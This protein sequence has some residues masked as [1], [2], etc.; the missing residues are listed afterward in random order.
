MQNWIVNWM[1]LDWRF[2]SEKRTKKNDIWKR[3]LVFISKNLTI[4][5]EKIH[6]I[7]IQMTS[8]NTEFNGE[9]NDTR[10][11]IQIEVKM[12]E[13]NK[14]KRHWEGKVCGNYKKFHNFT[15]TNSL[16]SNSNDTKKC[17]IQPWIQRYSIEDA[18]RSENCRKKQRK[19]TLGTESLS[20]LQKIW[21]FSKRKFAEF[22][23]KWHGQMQNPKMN[24]AILDWRFKSKWN[25]E[26]K[27][28]NKDIWKRKFVLIT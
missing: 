28:K 20:W 13:K 22:E 4:S 15:R 8:G 27:A 24:L 23:F 2:E 21:Q 10:L 1:I 11:K 12:E 9:F 17:R 14:E 6:S 18:N 3:K 26:K 19:K 25:W 16:N 7:G 5:Q